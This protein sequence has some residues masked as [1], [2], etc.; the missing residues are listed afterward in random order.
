MNQDREDIEKF[1]H[2]T[3]KHR[4]AVLSK[5]GASAYTEKLKRDMEWAEDELRKFAH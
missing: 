2:L 3:W 1:L 4:E 5:S